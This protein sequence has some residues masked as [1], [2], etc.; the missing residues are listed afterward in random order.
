MPPYI[1]VVSNPIHAVVVVY[2]LIF[3]MHFCYSCVMIIATDLRIFQMLFGVYICVQCTVYNCTLYMCTMDTVS[4]NICEV[5]HPVMS[6]HM[7]CS[8]FMCK[9]FEYVRTHIFAAITATATAAAC[10]LCCFCVF[11]WMP[12]TYYYDVL[13]Q[14]KN[15][16]ETKTKKEE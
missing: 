7:H 12:C 3:I 6:K 5:P 14:N 1:M 16:P 9:L 8:M 10:D 4:R 15:E 13:K 11:C 2:W